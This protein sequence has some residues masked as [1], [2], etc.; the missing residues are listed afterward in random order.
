MA[1]PKLEGE[2]ILTAATLLGTFA[3]AAV[4]IPA[5]SYY[6]TSVGSGSRSL[7]DEIKFQAD[8]ATGRLWLF[9][10]DDNSDASTGKLAVTVSGAATTVTW[11]STALRDALGFN[12]NLTGPANGWTADNHAKYLHL[13]SCGRSGLMAPST[14]NGALEADYSL[15]MG[16]DGTPYAIAYSVRELDSMEFRHQR[17]KK[18]WIDQESVVN[19]S[20]ERFYRDVIALGLSLRFHKDRADDAT[21][22]WWVVENGGS[23]APR[24]FDERWV[25]GPECLFAI[26]Y[27]VRR[28]K[29]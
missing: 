29:S 8:T 21:Y 4:T 28:R 26:R 22:R 24:A 18:S 7:L 1:L 2:I 10:L 5:G 17:G 23:Y 15:S 6:L 14:S 25:D 13:P 27:I 3:G 20:L 16:T 12:G 11:A 19:E 9:V